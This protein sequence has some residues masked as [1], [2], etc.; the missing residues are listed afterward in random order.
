LPAVVYE[1]EFGPD[2]RWM[3]VSPQIE[4]LVGYTAEEWEADP[5]LWAKRLHP[6]DRDEVIELERRDAETA[7]G[8]VTMISEYRLLHRDGHVIWVRDEARTVDS[9]NGGTYWRGVLIDITEARVAQ[10]ALSEAYERYRGL[11]HGLPICVYRTC[12]AGRGR[13]FATPQILRLLGDPVADET[14]SVTLWESSL[15]PDDRARVLGEQERQLAKPPGASM[16]S[17]YRLVG[18]QR[19]VVWVRDRGLVTED[20]EGGRVIDG[21]LADITA[22]RGAG[23]AGEASDIVRISCSRCGA[24]TVVESRGPCPQCGHAEPAVVSLNGLL[25]EL[26]ASRT[27]VETLLEGI[28]QHLESLAHRDPYPR[29]QTRRSDFRIVSRSTARRH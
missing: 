13:E 27:Q 1:S 28:H 22:T 16:V 18:H 2:G 17:E 25:A 29:P 24:V 12:V 11:V 9:G 7:P 15:H 21:L 19:Q 5:A 4:E 23:A 10:R 3:Y 6:D 20:E 14:P 8:S 26:D